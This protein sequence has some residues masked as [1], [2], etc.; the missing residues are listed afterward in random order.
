[1]RGAKVDITKEMNRT[2]K[3]VPTVFINSTHTTTDKK[4]RLFTEM[5]PRMIAAQTGAT[6]TCTMYVADAL[7]PTTHPTL[8][9]R[10]SKLR[11]GKIRMTVFTGSNHVMES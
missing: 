10:G 4:D 11:S 2:L 7:G 6:V 1:M 5:M 9:D 8:N 3:M